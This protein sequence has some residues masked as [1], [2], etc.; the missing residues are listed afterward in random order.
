MPKKIKIDSITD[1]ILSDSMIE[2]RTSIAKMRQLEL[3]VEKEELNL[4]ERKNNICRIDVALAEFDKFLV[5]FVEMLTSL[6]DTIQGFIPETTPD[7][8]K[9]IQDYIDDQLQRLA[10]KRLYLAIE[11]TAQEK[12]LATATKEESQ[13]KAARMKKGK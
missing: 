6:P 11:S 8:Y 9:K 3:G 5:D 12:A 13:K 4:E 1:P 2:R 10:K 7:Q